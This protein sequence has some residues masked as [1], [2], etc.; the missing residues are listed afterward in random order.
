LNNFFAEKKGFLAWP[1][2]LGCVLVMGRTLDM[3]YD[4]EWPPEFF[5]MVSMPVNRRSAFGSLFNYYRIFRVHSGRIK[6]L[7]FAARLTM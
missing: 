6:S 3:D 7:Y 1:N 5:V 4:V 2:R